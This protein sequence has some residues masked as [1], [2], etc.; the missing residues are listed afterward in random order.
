MI[1]TI[2][3]L[4]IS[5]PSFTIASIYA[6]NFDPVLIYSR[7]RSPVERWM[8]LYFSTKISHCL[9][10]LK[11]TC[12]C[13]SQVLPAQRTSSWGLEATR[14]PNSTWPWLPHR[15]NRWSW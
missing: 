8:N 5:F 1:L 10:I 12:L 14:W 6:P 13:L 11:G 9:S 7:S 4:D 3:S 2:K 15:L